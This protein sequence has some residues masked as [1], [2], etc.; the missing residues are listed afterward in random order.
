M[1]RH[2][3][4]GFTLVELLVVISIIGVLAALLLPAIQSSREAARR[5]TCSSNIRQIGI[6]IFN[7]EATFKEFPR[8]F[9]DSNQLAW[10]VT[11]LPQIEQTN[12]YN[13]FTFVQGS[14]SMVGKNQNHGLERISTYLCPSMPLDKMSLDAPSIINTPDRIPPTTTGLAPYTTHYYGL[15]GPRGTDPLTGA[16]YRTQSSINHEGVPLAEQG[17]MIANNTLRANSVLDGLSNTIVV[18]EM[19]WLNVAQGTRYRSWLRGGRLAIAESVASRNVFRPINS[20]LRMYVLTPFNDIPMGSMHRGGAHFVNGDGSVR[21]LNEVIDM[22]LYRGL[23]TRD[24]SENLGE[25]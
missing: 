16:A 7:Y 15:A 13:Q 22:Q 14:F 2:K 5:M 23:A 6:G 12:L 10:T 4:P 1:I 18:G 9:N 24:G 3:Q 17:L 21:F 19:S 20:G 25:F 11:I 8:S